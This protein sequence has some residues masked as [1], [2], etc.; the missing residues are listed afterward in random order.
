M[1][2]TEMGAIE[3]GSADLDPDQLSPGTFVLIA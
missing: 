3:M 2:S 1:D